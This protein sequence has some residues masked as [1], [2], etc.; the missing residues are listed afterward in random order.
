MAANLKNSGVGFLAL[1]METDEALV[2]KAAKT[3]ALSSVPIAVAESETLGPLG[4]NQVPATLFIGSD[5]MI[6]AAGN[7]PKGEAFIR[8]RIAELLEREKKVK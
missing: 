3:W 5:G 8:R 6:I 4:V 7:G 1:S 2:R